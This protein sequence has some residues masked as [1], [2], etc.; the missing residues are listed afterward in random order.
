MKKV[1]VTG[2]A[3]CVGENVIKYLLSEG[4]YE[5]TALDLDN[6]K[7]FKR[8]KRYSKRVNV[9]YGDI[10]DKE[11]MGNLIKEN[12]YV[13]HLASVIPPYTD[14]YHNSREI[15]YNG[16]E[17]IIKAINKYNKNCFLIYA[18]TTSLYDNS[19]GA[20]VKENIKVEELSN[21][22]SLKYE[23]ENLI[24]DKLTNYTIFRIPL[25]LSD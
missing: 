2:A 18:S 21:F 10:C 9:I 16:T 11:L 23:L 1:L 13:I 3:G 12:D 6:K 20:N 25:V 15:E 5:I 17:N 14:L 4:M 24:K 22:S 7:S 19:L 8:L